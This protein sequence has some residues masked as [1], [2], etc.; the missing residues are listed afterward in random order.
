MIWAYVLFSVIL[1]L[2]LILFLPITV[3]ISFDQKFYFKIKFLGL[4]LLKVKPKKKIEKNDTVADKTVEKDAKSVSQKLKDKNGFVGA[5]REI[6]AFFTDCLKHLKWLLGFVKFRKVK[7]DLTVATDNA[8]QTA[9]EY[10]MVC[11]IVYPV[12][13]FFDSIA[14]V[15]LRQINVSSD[16]DSKQSVFTFSLKIKLQVLFLLIAV[17]KIF[18]DYKKFSL[19][20]DLL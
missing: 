1:F 19:R 12:L 10:G 7:V 18:K 15:K 11:G 2:I 6:F 3:S 16:F 5:I 9:I 14:N 13:S 20:N 17:F 8:A 4:N